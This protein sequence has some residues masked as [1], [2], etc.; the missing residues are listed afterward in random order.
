MHASSDTGVNTTSIS[1]NSK[2]NNGKSVKGYKFYF[3]ENFNTVPLHSN[4]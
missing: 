3:K 2:L 4:M 1:V